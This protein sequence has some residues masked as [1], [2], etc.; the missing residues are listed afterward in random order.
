MHLRTGEWSYD[1]VDQEEQLLEDQDRLRCP[2]GGHG[3]KGHPALPSHLLIDRQVRTQLEP[4]VVNNGQVR[5][6]DGHLQLP[7]LAR[8]NGCQILHRTY[9]WPAETGDCQLKYICTISLN[10]TQETWLVD[11]HHKLLLNQTGMYSMPGCRL[12]LAATQ[13]RNLYLVDLSLPEWRQA[14]QGLPQVSPSEKNEQQETG[15]G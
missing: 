4:L 9:V 8:K 2:K 12:T 15:A 13:L 10:R 5:S 14:V 1:E 11:H 6:M 7:C 3:P